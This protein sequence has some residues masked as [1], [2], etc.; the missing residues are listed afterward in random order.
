MQGRQQ[1]L[2]EGL[3]ATCPRLPLDWHHLLPGLSAPG[4]CLLVALRG[5]DDYVGRGCDTPTYK[6]AN[7]GGKF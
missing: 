2:R 6:P 4:A 5:K 1:E 3:G 7:L